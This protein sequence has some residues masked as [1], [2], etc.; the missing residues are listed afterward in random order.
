MGTNTDPYQP[1]EGRY[2]LTRGIVDAL[3]AA[4]NPFSILTKSTMIAAR[5]RRARGGGRRGPTC[6]A[7]FSIGTLDEEVWRHRPSPA[8][9]RPRAGVEAVARLTDAGIPCGVLIAPVLPGLSDAPDAA[10]GGGRARASRPGRS[11]VSPIVLHLRPGVR[12]LFMPW[13]QGVRPDLVAA[14]SASTTGAPATRTSTTRAS[15]PT[16]SSSPTGT[17]AR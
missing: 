8:R 7:N 12:E 1:A 6:A 15:P 16:C 11:S 3:A 17:A 9:R 4:G 10:R 14:T 5:P 13:L 2:R